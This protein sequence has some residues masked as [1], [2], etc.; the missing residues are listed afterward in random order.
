MHR[1]VLMVLGSVAAWTQPRLRAAPR[2]V[3]VKAEPSPGTCSL[4]S[5]P[6]FEACYETLRAVREDTQRPLLTLQQLERLAP[7]E[8][9]ALAKRVDF[10]VPT[11]PLGAARKFFAHPTAQFIVMAFLASSYGRRATGAAAAASDVTAIL[12]TATFWIIQEHVIHDKLLHSDE[13][14]FGSVDNGAADDHRV[15]GRFR[16]VGWREPV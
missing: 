10:D 6:G 14:W 7:V 1:A 9:K 13:A 11:T 15:R 8:A 2:A 4:A 16:E 3:A 5:P 12:A